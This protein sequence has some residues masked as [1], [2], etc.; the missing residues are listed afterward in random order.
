MGTMVV[1]VVLPSLHFL[2]DVLQR[3]ELVDVEKL[4]PQPAVERLDQTIVGGLSGA[5]VVELDTSPIGPLIKSFGCKFGAVVYCD[6]L[7]PSALPRDP[8]QRLSDTTAREREAGLQA[9]TLATPLI[10]HGE[11]A[12]CS[13]ICHLVVYEVHAPVLVWPGCR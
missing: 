2:A 5:C 1:V 11:N 8:I 12:E 10:D 13:P 3:D 6:C 7:G 4:I 9:H